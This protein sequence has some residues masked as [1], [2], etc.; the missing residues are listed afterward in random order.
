MCRLSRFLTQDCSQAYAYRHESAL[1][2]MRHGHG[3]TLLSQQ[4]RTYLWRDPRC[5]AKTFF[6]SMPRGTYTKQF[7]NVGV[8]QGA[9]LVLAQTMWTANEA[10][11]NHKQISGDTIL[12]TRVPNSHSTLSLTLLMTV[13][14]RVSSRSGQRYLPCFARALAGLVSHVVS[15]CR[16]AS[17]EPRLSYRY[18]RILDL[19]NKVL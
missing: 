6:S 5:A 18:C 15:C 17:R 8:H 12:K 19:N 1:N 2:K 13:S 10:I 7:D 4:L 9:D 11:R 14:V 16:L 3:L